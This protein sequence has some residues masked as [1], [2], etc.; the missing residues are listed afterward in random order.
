M[1]KIVCNKLV[2][3]KTVDHLIFLLK[4]YEENTTFNLI[5][6]EDKRHLFTV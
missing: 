5:L 4:I 2:V 3:N 1:K 6:G